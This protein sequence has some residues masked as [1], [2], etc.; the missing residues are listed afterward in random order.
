[1]KDTPVG[2][3]AFL[4]PI[5]Y[6]N[7][8]RYVPTNEYVDIVGPLLGSQWNVRKKAF[9]TMCTPKDWESIRHGWKIHVSTALHRAADTLRAVTPVLAAAGVAFKFCSD[10]RMLRMSLGKNWSRFQAGKFIAVYPQTEQQFKAVIQALHEATAHLIGPHVLTDR[11]YRD[12]KAVFYRYGA[13]KGERRVD[14][15]GN[16][17]PGYTLEDGSWFD[18]IRGPQF[19]MPPGVSDPFVVADNTQPRKAAPVLLK[20][21][22]LVNG[23]L[24]FNA[25]GGIYHGVD[26]ETGRPIVIREVRGMLGHLT[27]EVPDDP[28]F[29]LRRE[30]RILQKLS[31]TGLVPEYVDLFQE[32]QNSFL[33]EEQL[34][35]MS[36]WGRSMDFYYSS[37]YQRTQFGLDRML[38]TIRRI[39]EGLRTIHSHGVVLRDLTKNNVMFTAD[40]QVKF[41][42]LEFAYE[43]N[44]DTQWINGWTP[45]YASKEQTA[46][47]RPRPEDDYYALGAL[48][49]DMLTFCAT[50]L[51]L[52]REAIL[53]HKLRQVL[54]D[55]GLPSK[56]QDVVAGLTQIEPEQRWNLD[57]VLAHLKDVQ[58]PDADVMM[59]PSRENMLVI[60]PATAAL[61]TQLKHTIEGMHRYIDATLDLSRRDRLWPACPQV[62]FTNPVSMQYG[63]TGIAWFQWRSRRGIEPAVLDWIQ[64]GALSDLCPPGLY[65]GLAGVALLFLYAGREVQ[66]QTLLLRIA[67]HDLTYA[68]PGLYFGAAGYGLVNLHYWWHLGEDNYL[69]EAVN[70]GERLLREARVSEHGRYWPT[71]N[72]I[73]L[74]LGDGQAG[75]ALFLTYLA[76][77]TGRADFA[78]AAGNAL[79]FDIA[80]SFRVAGRITWR[81]HV[82]S[83]ESD[84]NLPHMRFGSAGIGSACIRYHAL[85]GD[86]R[87]LDVALDCAYS[88]RTR[89]TNKIWQDSGS[90]GLGEFLLDMHHFT[91]DTRYRDI[92]YYHAQAI[93]PHALH[94]PEGIAFA[95]IEHQRVCND[96]SSGAAGIGVFFDRLLHGKSRLLMLD[97]LLDRKADG[98]HSLDQRLTVDVA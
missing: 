19:R 50:G 80:H 66:G 9:W 60:E 23:A 26:K 7:V 79:D 51:E 1:M 93:L 3:Y 82:Q 59:F 30:A 8:D 68:V 72:H 31:S 45:G 15:Y 11:A 75:V 13:H 10:P 64:S 35:A 92:A 65:P 22:Y 90:A 53:V 46:L 6:E 24:K 91:G 83:K 78:V 81:Y 4:D 52:G 89:V 70:V 58:L 25:T 96:Y 27:Q 18:D 49:L 62:F 16:Q 33:V 32:W 88:V 85:T 61:T 5:H 67:E 55:L 39:A 76:A 43:L 38:V 95:G 84:P 40:G 29:A 69:R 44:D 2:M 20:G 34:D 37:E 41:I 28:A 47:R 71:D 63:A 12:S 48:I 86:S 98:M 87:Y 17:M 74:G 57:K 21:R 56:L 42:D 97:D 36:L 94:F 54:D 77:A 73:F 14:P